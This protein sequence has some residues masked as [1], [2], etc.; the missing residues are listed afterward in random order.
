MKLGEI[1]T[2]IP[3]LNKVLNSDLSLPILNRVEKI[4]D[5]LQRDIKFFNDEQ[6]KIINKNNGIIKGEEFKIP[7]ENIDNFNKDIIEL[8]NTDVDVEF[9]HLFIDGDF[10]NIRM[11]HIDRQQL[12]SF[13]SIKFKESDD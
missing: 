12:K 11:K 2:A 1:M 9:K 8:L 6:M 5:A 13:I 3:S 10:E 7:P 4:W